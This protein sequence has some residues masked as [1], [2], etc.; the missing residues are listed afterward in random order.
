VED[1]V[2]EKGDCGVEPSKVQESGKFL[3]NHRYKRNYFG[4]EY[5]WAAPSFVAEKDFPYPQ[6]EP[7]EEMCEVARVWRLYIDEATTFDMSLIEGC[8]RGIDVL[9]VFVSLSRL[10]YSIVI[11]QFT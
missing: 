10:K 2:E 4:A 6:D 3:K 11:S 1:N 7:G 8:N 5:C 9:L